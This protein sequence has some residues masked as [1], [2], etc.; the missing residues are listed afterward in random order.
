MR[1]DCP[2]ASGYPLSPAQR[3]LRF[4]WAATGAVLLMGMLWVPA[5]GRYFKG[6]CR[7]FPLGQESVA[8]VLQPPQSSSVAVVVP[9]ALAYWESQ[10]LKR[11][12]A[13]SV[14]PHRVAH[15]LLY[16]PPQWGLSPK[17]TLRQTQQRLQAIAPQAHLTT[18][19]DHR[20]EWG[21]FVV[22][23]LGED[24]ADSPNV[25][26]RQG[27]RVV[28]VGTRQYSMTHQAPW[29]LW[30]R[31]FRPFRLWAAPHYQR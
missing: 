24:E 10:R 15:W 20:W 21:P 3:G 9:L 30:Q 17:Q 19:D 13:H 14:G 25:R 22:E 6:E 31:A 7:L 23:P 28:L 11:L 26:I 16:G 8:V 27:Q 18:V 2:D 1:W 29:V 4:R 12:V 5:V